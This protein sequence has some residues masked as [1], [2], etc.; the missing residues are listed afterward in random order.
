MTVLSIRRSA[1]LFAA[2]RRTFPA[3]E[4]FLVGSWSASMP[5]AVAVNNAADRLAPE[6]VS[7]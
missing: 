1:A 2:T 4:S 6:E 3:K 7:V 5:P